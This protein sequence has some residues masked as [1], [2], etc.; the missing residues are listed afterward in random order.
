LPEDPVVVLITIDAVRADA[1]GDPANASLFPTLTALA[2]QGVSF[3]Q[4]HA[5][6]SQTAL[7]LSALFSGRPFSEQLWTEHGSGASRFYYPAEDSS[8]RFPELLSAHGV[9]TVAFHGL[10]FLSGEY[11]VTRGFHDETVV[12]QGIR[13]AQASELVDR[14]IGRLRRLKPGP[15]FLYTHLMEPHEPYD[16]GRLDGTDEERYLSEIAVADAQVARVWHLL[17]AR[18]PGRWALFVSADHGEAFGDHGTREHGK[19]LYE[20][21]IHVPLFAIGPAFVPRVV[22]QRVSLLDL[23]PTML[24][25]FGVATPATFVGQSLVPLLAGQD[26]TLDRPLFAEGRLRRE[27]TTAGGLVAIEDLRRKTAEVYDLSSD[28]GETRN[29]FDAE[30]ARSDVALATLRA[31]FSAHTRTRDGYS[32]PFTP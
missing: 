21:L 19:T 2:R 22:S 14:L 4:A 11:G 30:P 6:G 17:E 24:D 32:P 27:L 20:E 31:F 3:T 10:G 16:R 29:L 25:L 23:G 12:V 15:A 8:V 26:V 7:S 5:A 13:H 9:G 18:F 28:P 1:V